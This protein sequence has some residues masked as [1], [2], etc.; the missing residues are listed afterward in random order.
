MSTSTGAWVQDLGYSRL[1]CAPGSPVSLK[2]ACLG[3]SSRSTHRWMV[4]CRD[5]HFLSKCPGNFDAHQ[6]LKI[7]AVKVTFWGMIS[8]KSGQLQ[9]AT[10]VDWKKNLAYKECMKGHPWNVYLAYLLWLGLL[11]PC[12]DQ[13]LLFF[14]FNLLTLTFGSREYCIRSSVS[15]Y[16][17]YSTTTVS[18]KLSKR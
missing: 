15:I 13:C 16:L 12:P 5:L 1:R 2:H 4:G 6:S 18:W 7:T 9:W 11:L 10:V 3:P 17:S 14:F 8:S